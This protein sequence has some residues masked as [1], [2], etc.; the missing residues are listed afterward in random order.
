V[1]VVVVGV[2]VVV[3][4]AGDVVVSVAPGGA[5]VAPGTAVVL[6]AVTSGVA[7]DGV[8]GAAGA[9]AV[10]REAPTL[11][12]RLAALEL[13]CAATETG[14]MQTPIK[15]RIESELRIRISVF[16]KGNKEDWG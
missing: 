9:V 3:A 14:A 10:V 15:A 7:D 1:V 4:V 6:G 13:C 16:A 2:V 12:D 11:V 8:A 5:V